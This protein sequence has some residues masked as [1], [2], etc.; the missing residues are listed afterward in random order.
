M[1]RT[2][3]LLAAIGVALVF[4]LG[5]SQATP[6]AA[7]DT[8]ATDEQAIR[9][10]EAAWVK[11]FATKD[12]EKVAAHY[13]D[14]GTSMIPLMTLMKGK[15]AIRAGL[16]E[17]FSD[18]NSS[19]DFHPDKVEVS[20]SGDLAYSQGK[21]AFTSTDPKTKKRVI[22][23]GGYVEVYKKQADGSWKVAQDIASQEAPPAP[24]KPAK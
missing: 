6:P 9:D 15:D 23:H 4:Q 8:R 11:D 12:V 5:C 21:Y 3:L 7:S 10:G 13:A 1:T 2:H 18:A 20:K 22:E 14:D 19:L 17:E 16:K 24:E